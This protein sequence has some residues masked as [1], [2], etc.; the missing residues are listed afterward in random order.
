MK[1]FCVLWIWIGLS[2]TDGS[3]VHGYKGNYINISCSHSWASDNKKFF[4]R[5][6]CNDKNDILV[7]SDKSPK[8]R[9]TLNDYGK[10]VFIVTITD[11]KESDS[12]VYWCGV[13]RSIKNTHRKVELTVSKEQPKIP[14]TVT[15]PQSSTKSVISISLTLDDFSSSSTAE[16]KYPAYSSRPAFYENATQ[17][18]YQMF[19][20]VI[21]TLVVIIFAVVLCLVYMRK[22]KSHNSDADGEMQH[23]TYAT[24]TAG[25]YEEITETQQQISTHSTYCNVTKTHTANQNQD[26]PPYSLLSFQPSC[27][28]QS[29]NDSAD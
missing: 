2:A 16:F 6:P 20:P 8:G 11:L 4:C 12:G 13:E 7:N 19:T 17:S 14:K 29:P 24:E 26:L 23:T 28:K 10:G 15:H 22:R 27:T 25:D 18:D 3:S 9:Y 5:D 21:L 1:L